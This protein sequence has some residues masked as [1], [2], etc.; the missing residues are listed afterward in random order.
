MVGAPVMLAVMR[1]IESLMGFPGPAVLVITV[2]ITMLPSVMILPKMARSP[3]MGF[4]VAIMPPVTG[5]P[6]SVVAN[7]VTM[8]AAMAVGVA[9]RYRW[10]MVRI[11]VMDQ[12]ADR[13]RRT[14]ADGHPFP[15]M[16]LFGTGP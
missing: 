8:V 7:A 5:I 9:N 11:M 15:A 14:D 12:R 6:I 13:D 10:L 1:R 3:M 2:P 16:L 4:E